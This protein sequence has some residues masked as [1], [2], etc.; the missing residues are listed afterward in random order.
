MRNNRLGKEDIYYNNA[1]NS[2]LNRLP[3]DFTENLKRF[4]VEKREEIRS[5]SAKL[6]Y[7]KALLSL[8]KYRKKPITQYR[9]DDIVDWVAWLQDNDYSEATISRH[10]M[11]VR[12]FFKWLAEQKGVKE[13]KEAVDWWRA[14]K[15]YKRDIK[16]SI[17]THEDIMKLVE[18]A[19]HPRTKAMV[20]TLWESGARLGEFVNLRVGDLRFTKLG[21]YVKI[22]TEKID[23]G[24]REILL[25]F[26][27]PYLRQWL[28]LHPLKDDPKAP[29]W[30]KKWR[31]GIKPITQRS[32]QWILRDLGR[33]ASKIYKNFNKRV[34]AHAFRHSRA[35][36]LAKHLTDEEMDYYFGWV[37]GSKMPGI[38]VHLGGRATLHIAK[39]IY[40]ELHGEEETIEETPL[41][42]IKCPFCE[43]KNPA[44][45]RFCLNCGKALRVVESKA[46]EI[47][48][49][50]IKVLDDIIRSKPELAR[51][52]A[53]KFKK[54]LLK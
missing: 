28:N 23:V 22:K 41:K 39:K 8:S 36:E 14:S 42:P 5:L 29:L 44:D 16:D 26:S 47:V 12:R 51:E 2:I 38:Y 31:D 10:L 17:F 24:Y 19:D 7:A 21:V 20:I 27:E 37:H 32:I 50:F 53:D 15:S 54:A 40:P 18:V 35:T 25:R 45:A 13:L 33:R 34:F 43:Y 46:V 4:F 52:F 30:V 9:K 1:L 49:T 3:K 11:S 48:D 6:N